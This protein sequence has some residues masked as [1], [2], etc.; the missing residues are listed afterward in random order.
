MKNKI[1]TKKLYVVSLTEII[2]YSSSG[3]KVYFSPCI[4]KIIA[5]KHKKIFGDIYY[6]DAITGHIFYNYDASDLR[7]G[8]I[9]VLIANPLLCD[10]KYITDEELKKLYKHYNQGKITN[11]TNQED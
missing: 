8:S 7:K 3:I 2:G 9:A 11:I 4:G 6:K 10:E 1:P 5:T